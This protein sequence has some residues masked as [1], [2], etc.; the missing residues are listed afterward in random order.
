[1]KSYQDGFV[2]ANGIQLHYYRATPPG[3]GPAVVLLHGL[4]DNGLCWVRVAEALRERYDVIM[5]DTRGHGLSDKPASG[6]AI[7]ELAA[8]VAGLIDA[9]G[10]KQPVLFGHSL[11]GQAATAV[12]G[13]YPGRVRAAVLED[14]AWFASRMSA[15]GG[16]E[17]VRRWQSDLLHQQSLE[18]PALIA[19]CHRDNP[20]WHADELAAWADAKYQMS[21]AALGCI[22]SEVRGGWQEHVRRA[23][24]PLL[25]VTAEPA[26]GSIITPAMVAEAAGLWKQGREAHI[27]GAGHCIHR[28]QLAATM[29]AVTQ[30]LDEVS[31]PGRD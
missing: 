5:P 1:M 24:C 10:L 29:A 21:A 6:Y 31:A 19:E 23:E 22:L 11:G 27:A 20:G 17:T 8:D 18:K 26:R 16:E 25:L 4:T 12:A 2:Q 13:L 3:G 28:D 7:E 15:E 30:F 9:L 14:P